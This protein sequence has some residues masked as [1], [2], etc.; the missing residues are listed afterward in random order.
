MN[1]R[2]AKT[3]TP[4]EEPTTQLGEHVRSLRQARGLS[5]RG[6]A[7]R[8]KVDATWVSRLENGVYTSP[9]P[10]YLSRLAQALGIDVEDL[11]LD[12]GYNLTRGL[13]G[14]KVY[15]RSKY[16]YLPPEAIA[17]LQAHFDLINEKYQD[18]KGDAP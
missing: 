4:N 10:R 1:D 15:F 2:I 18:K 14:F 17:Q 11:Y 12:A 16:R 7:S 8:A 9:D 5:V 3:N 6:L 13:P